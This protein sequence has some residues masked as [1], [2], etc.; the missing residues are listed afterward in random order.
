MAKKL[1]FS[2]GAV[3][4]VTLLGLQAGAAE[5]ETERETRDRTQI[6]N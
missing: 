1:V 3:M 4:A 2:V 5:N 6:E